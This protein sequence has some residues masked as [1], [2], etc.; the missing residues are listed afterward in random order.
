[1]HNVSQCPFIASGSATK[2]H[3]TATMEAI[4]Y[5]H[6]VCPS[7]WEKTELMGVTWN[8]TGRGSGLD[9]LSFIL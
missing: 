5:A 6:T 9:Q 8:G 4:R 3:I 2:L 1:M 7:D